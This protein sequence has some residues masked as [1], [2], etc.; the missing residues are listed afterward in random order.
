MI[1]VSIYYGRMVY[2]LKWN[3]VWILHHPWYEKW[4]ACVWNYVA[5]KVMGHEYDSRF[6][7]LWCG[8]S[9]RRRR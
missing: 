8:K 3:N 5:C 2:K 1:G 6:E 9:L 7:C 4:L